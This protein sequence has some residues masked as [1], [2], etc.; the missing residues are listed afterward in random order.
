MRSGFVMMVL[1]YF[2]VCRCFWSIL[3]AEEAFF[4]VDEVFAFEVIFDAADLR[5]GGGGFTG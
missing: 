1:C 5:G 2:R 4:L 3:A